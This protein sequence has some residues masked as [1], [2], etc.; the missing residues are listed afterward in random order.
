MLSGET[1]MGRYPVEAVRT[2]ATLAI[3]A[4][5]SLYEYGYLQKVQLNPANV[6]TEAVGQA[7]ATMAQNLKAAAIFSLT[8]TGFTSR[9]I[10][11]H[12][13]ECPILAVTSSRLVARRL[14]LN[15]GVIPVLYEGPRADEARI[16]YGLKCARERGYLRPRD[17]VIITAGYH[18]HA[19]GTDSIRV[20]VVDES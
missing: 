15:W 9:L 4:E 5:A 1:A 3:R 20:I 17:V 12:R 16:A 10:S 7:A 6:I 2:M 13:P 14:A 18:Q 8:E 11:K 19:G